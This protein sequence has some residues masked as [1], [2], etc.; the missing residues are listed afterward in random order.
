[1]LRGLQKGK[2]KET[3]AIIIIII[4]V[5]IVVIVKQQRGCLAPLFANIVKPNRFN[6]VP[7]IAK[8]TATATTR[9]RKHC[10]SFSVHS[11]QQPGRR[12]PDQPTDRP[13]SLAANITMFPH[14]STGS[15]SYDYIE[16]RH[17]QRKTRT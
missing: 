9:H 12:Y 10:V 17:N 14:Q 11:P 7:G 15:S 4:I 2:R 13:R 1:M 8:T 5:V 6:N 16:L 3:I